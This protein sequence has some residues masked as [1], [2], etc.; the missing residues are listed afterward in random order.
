MVTHRGVVVV[1]TVLALVLMFALPASADTQDDVVG[2]EPAV[3]PADWDSPTEPATV[4]PGEPA[5]GPAP[6]PDGDTPVTDLVAPDGDVRV[7]DL[8]DRS[9]VDTDVAGATDGVPDDPVV[10]ETVMV[11]PVS[12]DDTPGDVDEAP[13]QWVPVVAVAVVAAMCGGVWALRRRGI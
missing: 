13:A 1:C 12:V 2:T 5:R 10:A 3:T 9:V 11:I 4:D 6:A 8:E 7:T